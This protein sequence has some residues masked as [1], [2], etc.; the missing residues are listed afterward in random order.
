MN[1]NYWDKVV[2]RR[3]SRRRALAAA[4]GTAAGAAFLAACGG[5]DSDSGGGTQTGSG[6]APDPASGKQGGKMIWQGYGD[7]GGTT[8]MIKIRN[9]GVHQLA[10]L[11]HDA[12]L[13]FNNGKPQYPPT[14]R[15]VSPNLAVALPEQ[16]PD[17]LTYTF[18]MKT[19]VKFHNGRVATAEDM[20]W[21][22]E[23]YA[24]AP[25]S[26]FKND[27]IWLDSVQAPDAQTV[28]VKT[29]F[30]FADT[31]QSL[32]GKDDGELLA[33][34]HHEGPDA[35]T[36]L[37]GTGPFL[38][39]SYEP[40][41]VTRYKRNPEYHM[42]PYP[43]FEEIERTGNA[44]GEKKLADFIS[45]NVHMSYWF[46]EADRD[47]VKQ[48]RPDAQLWSYDVPAETVSMRTDKPPF[49]DERVRQA[50]SMA[51][52]R[53]ALIQ[54]LTQ[55]EGQTDQ[56]LSWTGKF[57]GF[58]KP[59]EL[60]PNAKYFEQNIQ[61]AKQLL[62]AAGVQ[63]PL[64]GEMPHWNPTVI[65]QKYVD[66]IV[67]I[68]THWRNAGIADY[69]SVEMTHAQFSSGPLLGN[70]ETMTWHPN[71]TAIQAK[72]GLTVRNTLSWAPGV[73]KQAPTLNRSY[74]DDPQLT[75]LVQKQMGQ[76]NVEER[77]ATFRQIEDL[78]AKK[79]YMI[80]GVTHSTNWFADPSLKNTQPAIEMY[81]GG[82][83]Y[84]K[85]WWFG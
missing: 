21:S 16:A 22:L 29:K 63:L 36:K 19:G 82:T 25:E 68:M 52:D 30:P 62:S 78:L 24:F 8:E 41:I 33:R 51:I 49:N 43:Y 17:G 39:V 10:G 71:V 35:A 69:K 42:K 58:R 61:E 31:L 34:E 46:P 66:Q 44:D 85:Y 77:K 3:I 64:R 1:A 12:L 37:L 70:Y 60:G 4:G 57:W 59:S 38:F 32:A 53:K 74:I 11:T 84:M 9:A 26:A 56:W 13:E 79:Q 14:T 55:G 65:G 18:K 54:A 23:A 5:G 76:F 7:V 28:V 80:V 2:G 67:L 72:I 40:P 45:R 15:E 20:K 50:L 47:R 48:A 83:N 6:Q 73:P 27:Y 75:E 81:N